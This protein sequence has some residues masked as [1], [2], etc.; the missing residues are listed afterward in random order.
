MLSLGKKLRCI[1]L[2][3]YVTL[4]HQPLI[5]THLPGHRPGRE[6]GTVLSGE[7]VTL[8]LDVSESM[9]LQS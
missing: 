1:L 7:G 8:L 3:A 2:V 6:L 5:S 4:A 9:L